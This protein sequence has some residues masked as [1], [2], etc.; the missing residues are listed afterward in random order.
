MRPALPPIILAA[1]LSS[2]MGRNKLAGRYQ[3][4]SRC[5]ATR[6]DA[7]LASSGQSGHRRHRKR[8]RQRRGGAAGS[9]GRDRQQSRLSKGLST[10]LI[11]GIDALPDDCDGAVCCWATCRTSPRTLIDRLIAAFDPAEDRAICVATHRRQARQ[12]GAVVAAF[13]PD[14]RAL[15]GRCG[16]E[17][18]DWRRTPIL[19]AR[20][21]R[22]TMA[23]LL[24]IDTP[25]A[26]AAYATPV[27]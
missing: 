15:R 16:R 3:R 4:T 9:A 19:F 5:C 10:S 24:D 6:S 23:R 12:S 26:L 18:T 17:V 7:A 11:A 8:S 14:I 20:S 13:F 27:V 22:R 1:G 25:E 21:K 2:R